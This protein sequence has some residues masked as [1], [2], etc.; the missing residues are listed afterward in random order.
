MKKI[1]F[2]AEIGVN[3][4]ANL[5]KAYELIKAAKLGGV[6]FDSKKLRE[7]MNQ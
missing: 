2:I 5:K 4:E 3:H 7:L 1:Y 6:K